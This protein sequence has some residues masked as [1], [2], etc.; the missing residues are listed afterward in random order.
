M[1]DIKK[2]LQ[3]NFAS[4]FFKIEKIQ[5]SDRLKKYLEESKENLKVEENEEE[6]V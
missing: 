1:D 5:A 2:D 4:N 6:A 3:S